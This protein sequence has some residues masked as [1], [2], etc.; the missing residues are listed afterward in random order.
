MIRK[1]FN[2][3]REYIP[4]W[5][6]IVFA[7]T[8]VSAII[9][10][11]YSKSVAF[12]DIFNL[13]ISM[14]VRAVLSFTTSIFPFSIAEIILIT[15]PLWLALLI[16]FAIK[17]GKMGTVQSIRYLSSLISLICIVFIAYVWTNTSGF[18]N[19]PIEDKMN[20]DRENIT[21][22]ELYEASEII[23]E[24]LNELSLQIQ[25][26]EK[27]SSVMPYS[28]GEMSSKIC[29]AYES[30][31]EKYGL[32]PTFRSQIKPIMLSK[33]MTYTHLSGIYF[34]I[35]GESNVNVNYPDYIVASTSA[36]EMAHQRGLAREDEC[37]FVAFAVLDMSDDSFLKYSAYLDVFSYL[38][39]ELRGADKDLYNQ[40]VSKLNDEV[41]KDYN[42][43]V[44]FFKE[45][46][47]SKASQVTDKVNDTF[48]QANGQENGTKSYSMVT[49]LVVAYVLNRSK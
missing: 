29:D 44:E 15:L 43:Y 24:N 10:L 40:A 6:M 8:I 13:Y 47:N 16:Y 17:F 31:N 2:K 36:H 9:F 42:S 32:I 25:Y 34:C 11:I 12:A 41:K 30:F 28:Y 14:P 21:K 4:L 19:T 27:N 18:Y 38:I 7:I 22:E 39:A 26:N 35:T 46:S 49:E 45:Y 37:N 20:L 33:P 1:L 5:S 23:I 48:L 3:T